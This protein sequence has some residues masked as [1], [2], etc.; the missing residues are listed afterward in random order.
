MENVPIEIKLRKKSK[1]LS[2]H[3]TN[4]K[5]LEFSFEFLRVHSPSAEVKKHNSEEGVLQTNK[6]NV[7]I[8]SVKPVGNYGIKLVFDD[9]H[10]TGIFTWRYLKKLGQNKEKLWLTYLDQ[11]KSSGYTR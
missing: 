7:L 8:K 9:G 5:I 10:D 2:A 1:L 11:L 3:Y 6:Q 4:N